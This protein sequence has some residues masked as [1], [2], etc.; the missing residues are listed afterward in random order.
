MKPVGALP[1]PNVKP[2]HYEAALRVTPRRS[3]ACPA[4]ASTP[5]RRRRRSCRRRAQSPEPDRCSSLDPAQNNTFKRD[6]PR[7]EAGRDRAGERRHI[8]APIRYAIR[9]LPEQRAG[10]SRAVAGAA[11]GAR[12]RRRRAARSSKPRIGLY[13][14]WTGSMDEGWTRWVLEQYGFAL[15]AV[16]PDD[17]KSPLREKIDVLIIA[18]DARVPIAGAA[19]RRTRRRRRRPAARAPRVRV[20]ADGRRSAGLR[21]V[22]PRRRHGRLPEQRQHVRDPAAEAAG[23]KRGRG[24]AAGRVLPARIDRR[25]DDRSDASGDGR[26]AGDRRRCSSTA[27]RCSRRWTGFNGTRARALP[28]LRIAAAVR[29]SDRREALHGK[30]AALD[31]QLDAGHVVLLGFRPEWRGQPFGTF[32]VLFNAAINVR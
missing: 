10:R 24:S 16:H 7:V 28:G 19:R 12:R 30:A 22:R 21:A 18:D 11:G 23:E 1:D 27:A 6:Q 5:I 32:R 29:L 13:Q 4:S 8:G 15:R 25:G 31:V 14:P 9:G 3:T 17:F 2:T 26:H 20:P